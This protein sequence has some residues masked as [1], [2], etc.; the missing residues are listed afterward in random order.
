MTIKEKYVPIELAKKLKA[1]GFPQGN[2][3]DITE[4]YYTV[5]DTL[6]SAMMAANHEEVKWYCPTISQVLKWMRDML[7]IDVLP[8]V[9]ISWCG[10]LNRIRLY[11]C[12][13]YSPSLKNPIETVYFD[14]YEDAVI[15]GIKYVLN[16]LI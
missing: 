11:S 7:E 12:K 2:K 4:K 13:I 9:S 6:K 1:N 3:D 8:N 10:N 5:S 15:A 14:S 16:N